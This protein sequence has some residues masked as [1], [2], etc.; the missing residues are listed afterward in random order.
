MQKKCNFVIHLLDMRRSS[1]CCLTFFFFLTAGIFSLQLD[2]AAQT[3]GTDADR[4]LT[5]TSDGD[6]VISF[7]PRFVDFGDPITPSEKSDKKLSYSEKEKAS[8]FEQDRLR[9]EIDARR[10]LERL[11]GA[12]NARKDRAGNSTSYCVGEI[13]LIT[14]VTPTGARTYQIPISTVPD[15]RFAPSVSLV[16]NS[17]AGEGDA[18]YGWTIAGVPSISLVSKSA[19]YHGQV[20]AADVY[21]TSDPVFA[22]DGVPIVP[23]DDPATA[24]AFPYSTAR[25]HILVSREVNAQGFVKSFTALYPNGERGVFSSCGEDAGSNLPSYPLI[26]LE[27][28]QRDSIV[29]HYST[30]ALSFDRSLL[31]IQYAHNSSGSPQAV[32]YFTYNHYSDYRR[33]YY[34]GKE[35]SLGRYLSSVESRNELQT[36][37]RLDLTHEI[38]DNVPLLCQVASSMGG[39]QLKPLTFQYGMDGRVPSA[40]DSLQQTG[41]VY[42][43]QHFSQSDVAI[44]N[45]RGKFFAGR[46]DDGT[47]MYP[48]FDN[49]AIRDQSGIFKKKYKYGSDYASGQQILLAASLRA[50]TGVD[51]S[52]LAGSGFQTIAPADVDGDGADEIVRVNFGESTASGDSLKVSVYRVDSGGHPVLQSSRCF[53]LHGVITEGNFK[54]PYQRQYFWGD[55]DGSGRIRLLAIAYASNFNS[56]PQTSY[57]ALMDV[58]DGTLISEDVLFPFPLEDAGRVFA[59]DYDGDGRTELCRITGSGLEVYR[60][61]PNGHFSLAHAYSIQSLYNASVPYY[62]SDLNGDGYMD[63]ALAPVL[64]GSNFWTFY[65]FNGHDFSTLSAGITAYSAAYKFLFLD[66]NRDGLADLLR[67]DGSNVTVFLNKTGFGFE[68]GRVSRRILSDMKGL[69]PA[70]LLHGSGMSSFIKTEDDFVRLYEYSAPSPELR[71]LVS[72]EDSYSRVSINNY[73]FLPERSAFWT[74]DAAVNHNAGF[75]LKSLPI[76]VLSSGLQ[77]PSL[78][79]GQPF[80]NCSYSYFDPVVHNLGLGFCGFSHVQS[81]DST[82][83]SPYRITDT[84]F[85]PQR[86]GVTTSVAQRLSSPHA[87]PWTTTSY[88]Y[89]DHATVHGKLSPRLVRT[90]TTDNRTGIG[91]EVSYDFYDEYD[92]PAQVH[93]AKHLAPDTLSTYEIL[94]RTYIHSTSSSK[95]V[96]GVVTEESLV[97]ERDGEGWVSWKERDT[98]AYDALFR[99]VSRKHLVGLYDYS[100]AV[101]DTVAIDLARSANARRVSG[102]SRSEVIDTTAIYLGIDADS[103]VWE[104]RWTYD[105]FGNVISEKTAPYGATVFTGDSYAYD[106]QGRYM[107]LKTDAL[108]R[109]TTFSGY[110]K[111][112]NPASSTDHKGRTTSFTYD[113]W[114]RLVQTQYPDGT[115][116]QTATA[117]GGA[118][119]Y[120]VTRT[121]TGEPESVT[122]YDALGREIR[123]GVKRFDGQWQYMDKEYDVR[124]RLYRSSLPYRGASPTLWNVYAYDDYDRP[125]SITEASGKVS[126]WSYTGTSTTTVRDGITSTS[127][128]D[129]F[130]DVVQVVDDG[131]TIRYSLRDDG[132]PSTITAP[133]DIVTTL[134]Y[135]GYGRRTAIHDPSAGTRTTQESRLTDGSSIIV[136][137]NP[138][139]S[140]TTH[141]DRFGRT[142]LVERS[143]A[144]N[145][146]YTYGNDGLLQSVVSTNGA[147]KAYTYDS[148]DRVATETDTVAIM[149]GVRWLRKTFTYGPG[150]VVASI[151]YTTPD[152]DITTETYTYANGHNTGITLPD[153]TAVWSLVSENDLGAPTQILSGDV[154]RQYGYTATGLPTYRKMGNPDNGGLGSLQ[155]F[156]YQ[157]DPQT[158]NLQ[159][160]S[161]VNHN[162]AESFGYDSLDRLVSINGRTIT[163]DNPTGNITAIGGV[164]TMTY[165]DQTQPYRMTGFQPVSSDIV[166]PYPQTVTYTSFDRPAMIRQ[167][168][169]SVAFRYGCDGERVTMD[170]TE[171]FEESLLS[172]SRDYIGDR[173]ECE[174]QDSILIK[175]VLYLGGDAYSAPMAL[176]WNLAT[177]DWTL[178]NIGRDYLGSITQVATADGTLIDEYS[179]D[180]WGR[181]RDPQTLTI[182]PRGQEPDLLLG[183]G[184]TGHEHLLQFGLVNMNARLYD[185]LLGRFLYPDPYIQD[186]GFSQNYNRFAYVLNNPL[187]YSDESGEVL[188]EAAIIAIACLGNALISAGID[189]GIQVVMNIIQSR[190]DPSMKPRDIWVNK[191]DWFDVGI[192]G[193]TGAILSGVGTAATVGKDVGKFGVYLLKHPEVIA[194][195]ETILTSAVDITG[196]GVQPVTFNQFSQR[197]TTSLITICVT[198][199]INKGVDKLYDKAPADGPVDDIEEFLNTLPEQTHHY[200]TNKNRTYTPEFEKIANKYGLSLDGD[201]NKDLLHHLGKHPNEYHDFVLEAMKC[202]DA[203]ACGDQATFLQ[204][205]EQYVKSIVRK[206][207]I[208]LRKKGWTP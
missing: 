70:N 60:L 82:G 76:Y 195:S 15:A 123:G 121:A 122:H 91:M 22:L 31:Y 63:I 163:Y 153:G 113:A 202:I 198:N 58:A 73:R 191:I 74:D 10:A 33:S 40:Q 179:Y 199:V 169:D 18:G 39:E 24:Q 28:L 83:G 51:N 11:R 7:A 165:G 200:A 3:R 68:S 120:T 1:I 47:L 143:G 25:G 9:Q 62:I 94:S 45:V 128:T 49:Y 107:V 108:G 171:E 208:L 2:S 125:L 162:Q 37:Q 164:G 78:Y 65:V 26:H 137:T 182:Y 103:L 64:S 154:T 57:V 118:G 67:T 205:Y 187:K 12:S 23:N 131:G 90:V 138:N 98:I 144:H 29:F 133:G 117:W 84:Y 174:R 16:Y 42:L 207:P 193:V 155:H 114:G 184:F 100:D 111:F 52:L 189:Y 167:G 81:Y 109:T 132:Q 206:K 5:V 48:E 203:S 188:T 36:I 134:D 145:T 34:A 93:T 115:V 55:F 19:Y 99:P 80:E 43:T 172:W 127:T 50:I 21:D 177:P 124:G 139:G 142:T 159:S 8:A 147:S 66:V 41:S 185:P 79:A 86:M 119:L 201:W 181:L 13:P 96:L 160:R 141:S 106:S 156:T 4:T 32:I 72:S 176:A 105:S 148:F 168:T 44:A 173:Y 14:G 170:V 30:G 104:K 130:G 101:V 180:P 140:V 6:T 92:F 53:I 204:L 27:N 129:A 75:V 95:Y 190:D 149:G 112:G 61:G 110:D 183:R 192:S 136:S 126:T 197:L 46:F 20:K 194:L 178:Y 158:G 77:Y 157:F 161:D 35:L 135:D 166:S 102:S 151:R 87:T 196:E 88:T 89:D 69:S 186:P 97:R 17:Q 85:D 56:A 175:E 116:E 38:R 71:A 150:S 59:M 54:S 146:A 152:G